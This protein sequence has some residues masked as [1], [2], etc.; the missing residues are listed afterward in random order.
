MIA[1]ALHTTHETAQFILDHG[2]HYLLT[3]KGNQ[4]TIQ[5]SP[6]PDRECPRLAFPEVRIAVR[7]VREL[8]YE[9]TGAVR[10]T[11]VVYLL[12]ARR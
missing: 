10:S 3:A 5:V 8:I 12:A 7:S 9:K 2:L 11:Q 6:E 1:D 4:P